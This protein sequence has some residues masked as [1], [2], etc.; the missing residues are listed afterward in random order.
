LASVD[1]A[2]VAAAVSE[3]QQAAG[4]Y[5]DVH[6]WY[7]TPDSFEINV[8]LLNRLGFTRFGVERIYPTRFGAGEFWAILAL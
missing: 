6:A 3:W 5:L 8:G 1:P 4:Q 7:F 2:M